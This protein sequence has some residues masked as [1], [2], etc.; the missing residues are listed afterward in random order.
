[1]FPSAGF[2]DFKLKVEDGVFFDMVTVCIYVTCMYI[3]SSILMLTSLSTQIIWVAMW[4]TMLKPP[5]YTWVN[6]VNLYDSDLFGIKCSVLCVNM[7]MHVN[8]FLWLTCMNL[9]PG[10]RAK[11]WCNTS[12][13]I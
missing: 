8:D 5:C 2:S 1:M 12:D 6:E 4:L 13:A 7:I 3:Y 9:F 11:R 10:I